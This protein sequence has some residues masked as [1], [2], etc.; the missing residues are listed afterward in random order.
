VLVIRGEVADCLVQSHRVVVDADTREF[1]AQR[2][3]VVD[4]VK[5]WP[6]GLEV[7]EQRFD[8]A[9]SV[10]YPANETLVRASHPDNHY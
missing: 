8:P 7:A 5:V 6:L 1:G 3:G 10:G 2:S 4:G 9:W